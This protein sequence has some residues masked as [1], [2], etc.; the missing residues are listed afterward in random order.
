MP[1]TNPIPAVQTVK[2]SGHQFS[3]TG[4]TEHVGVAAML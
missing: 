3:N 2:Q 1:Y 4:I